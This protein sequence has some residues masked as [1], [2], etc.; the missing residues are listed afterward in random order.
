MAVATTPLPHEKHTEQRVAIHWPLGTGV[1]QA[2]PG[3]QDQPSIQVGGDL[4]AAFDIALDEIVHHS[5]HRGNDGG[6][7]NQIDSTPR[8]EGQIVRA[9]VLVTEGPSSSI[10]SHSGAMR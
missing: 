8:V 2:R 5:L 1:G 4:E 9:G 7:E 10:K 6:H 3:V